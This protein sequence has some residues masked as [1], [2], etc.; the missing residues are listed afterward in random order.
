MNLQFIVDGLLTGSMIGLGAIGVT[1]TYSILRFS[2]FAHG[3][4]MAWGTYATLAVVSAIGAIFGKVAP[5]GPLS[6]GWPLIVAVILA[7]GF[8]GV[9]ALA[10]DKVLFAR[11]R[12]KGQSIIV[13]MASFGASMALRSLLEFLF[14]SRPTYFSRAI[15]IAM[16][17]GFGIRITPDQI[18]LLIV[19]A[20]LVFGVHMLMTR[21]QTG[22]SM[23]ALSQNPALARVVGIDVAKVVRV[24]WLIGG[25]LACVAGVMI[26]ILVQIRPLMG[27]DM[28][29]PMFAAAI[30]GGIGS[31]P[32]AVLGGLIIGLAEAAAVQLVGAEW[33]AAISFI[34]LM[35]VLFIRPIG[36]FGVRER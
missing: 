20:L 34:I 14:T 2:N 17:V 32:G 4:F 30:L 3:D 7:M 24:T 18:A 31:V 25:G 27:F 6:F 21:T 8:T 33:R 10:L 16:P 28:L 12:A 5:I 11:L 13:V 36:L 29:L 15:Q 1:L 23:Q 19:T 35:A 26:G 22:R 9:L